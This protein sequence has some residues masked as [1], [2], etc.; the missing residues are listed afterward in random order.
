MDGC[1]DLAPP[2]GKRCDFLLFVASGSHKGHWV[3]P[4]ELKSGKVKREDLDRIWAQ[5]QTGADVARR[6]L[7]EDTGDSRV[8][9]RPILG[10]GEILHPLVRRTLTKAHY[11]VTLPGTREVVRTLLCG[12]DI[13]GR[14][15]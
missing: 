5:L 8:R 1:D 7:A 2:G 10:H 4:I 13:G 15:R 6:L 11:K 9:L 12:G 14:L 3:V